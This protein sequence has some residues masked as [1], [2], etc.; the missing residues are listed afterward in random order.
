MVI[1]ISSVHCRDINLL[2]GHN[3]NAGITEKDSN[4][5]QSFALVTRLK[6][7]LTP[8]PDFPE[9]FKQYLQEMEEYLQPEPPKNED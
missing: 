6:A 2:L 1:M 4:L 3:I 9:K 5:E 7:K 8:L